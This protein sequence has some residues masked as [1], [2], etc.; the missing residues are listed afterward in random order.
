MRGKKKPTVPNAM[1]LFL[2]WTTA[3]AEAEDAATPAFFFVYL[4]MEDISIIW[5]WSIQ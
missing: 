1:R 3:E 5:R 2:S 4:S